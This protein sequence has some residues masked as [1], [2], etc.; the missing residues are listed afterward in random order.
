[1]KKIIPKV[2]LALAPI[3]LYLAVFVAF[4]P[5]NYFGLRATGSDNSPISRIRAFEKDPHDSIILGDSRMAHFD[6]DLV[7]EVSGT[8]WSNLAYGGA[9]LEES[10]D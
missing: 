6:M 5:N 9:S 3:V 4:E 8:Q 1:M 7:D 10:I 2:A